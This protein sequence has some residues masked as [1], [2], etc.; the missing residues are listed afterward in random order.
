[1]EYIIEVRRNHKWQRH[2]GHHGHPDV[3]KWSWRIYKD[4]HNHAISNRG[5]AH[6]RWGAIRQ[7]KRSNK[8]LTTSYNEWVKVK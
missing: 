3:F 7:A 2:L 5:T 6:T 1:M 8:I 4:K